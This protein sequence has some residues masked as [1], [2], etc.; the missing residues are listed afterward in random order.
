M[1]QQESHISTPK[2]QQKFSSGKLLIV[3]A[4]LSIG[5]LLIIVRLVYLQIINY[6]EFHSLSKEQHETYVSLKAERGNIYDRN[7]RLLATTIRSYSYAIDPL[8]LKDTNEIINICN[9]VSI[10]TG[11]DTEA[12]I[13]KVTH[14]KGAFVWLA[15]GL[16]YPQNTILDSINKRGFIKLR[17]PKRNYL[18]GSIGA[19]VVGST[20]ID[21]IGLTGIEL[22]YDSVLKGVPGKILMLKDRAGRKIPTPYKPLQ[23][24]VSGKSIYLTIDIELQRIVEYELKNG[25]E[26][27][28]AESGSA[29]VLNPK[30]GEILAM[31]SFPSFDPN[32]PQFANSSNMRN[33]IISDTYEPGSTFKLITAAIAIQEKIIA[34]NDKVNG[35]NGFVQFEDYSIR[36]ENK[37]GYVKFHE[38]FEQSSN[39]VFSNIAYNIPANVLY[40]YIRDFNFGLNYGIGLHGEAT[41]KT[42]N[43]AQLNA[44]ARRFHGFGYGISVSSLQIANAYAA[45]AN[46]GVLMKPIILKEIRNSDNKVLL[47]NE[48]LKIRNIIS[49]KSSTILTKLLVDVVNKGTG[50]AAKIPGLNIAGKTGT[51]QQIL[52]SSYSKINY[53]ASFAGY[54][55]AENPAIT[56]LIVLDKPKANIYGGATA[57]PIFRNIARS[58]ISASRE[59]LFHI[60]K[61]KNFH[62]NEKKIIMPDLSGMPVNDAIRLLNALGCN[63]KPKSD[64]FIVKSHH[65]TKHQIISLKQVDSIKFT[66]NNNLIN[67][68]ATANL[69]LIGMS[70]NKAIAILTSHNIKPKVNG[71]G[72]VKQ[73]ILTKDENGKISYLLICE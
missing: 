9:L 31:A 30:T 15:R 23:D 64:N 14:A 36:D 58:W 37:L 24:A 21:N 11:A 63:L 53:T 20:D 3:F 51:A 55:P 38:A 4:L 66:A 45:V 70:L 13:H 46:K 54:F 68:K 42:K 71:S 7:G 60:E 2:H 47:V 56:M 1:K 49:D 10:A 65:P 28:N 8:I 73:Q 12:L 16:V 34:P 50:K 5:F 6:D 19:Q 22:S 17:E 61:N 40:K 72:K 29:I 62:Y 41:G 43:P 32:N 25:V 27:A 52:D 26:R 18:Y 39:I 33:R 44:V 69:N 35:H 57:A 48:P 67:D 59:M